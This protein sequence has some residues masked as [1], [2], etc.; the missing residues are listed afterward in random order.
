MSNEMMPLQQFNR[1]KECNKINLI[2]CPS[3]QILT[4]EN[5][6]LLNSNLRK[7]CS[8]PLKQCHKAFIN[9]I[10]YGNTPYEMV[11]KTKCCDCGMIL[12][13]PHLSPRHPYSFMFCK[14][15]VVYYLENPTSVSCKHCCGSTSSIKSSKDISIISKI[16]SFLTNT[17]KTLKTI[18]SLKTIKILSSE[19]GNGF[20]SGSSTQDSES[21]ENWKSDIEYNIGSLNI[22]PMIS[23]KFDGIDGKMIICDWNVSVKYIWNGMLYEHFIGNCNIPDQTIPVEYVLDGN[24]EQHYF[25][26]A[27]AHTLINNPYYERLVNVFKDVHL[28][29]VV[30]ID[31]WFEILCCNEHL[32]ITGLIYIDTLIKQMKPHRIIEAY[33]DNPQNHDSMNFQ[34]DIKIASTIEN[35]Y[36]PTVSSPFKVFSKPLPLPYYKIGTIVLPKNQIVSMLNYHEIMY[37]G[38]ETFSYVRMRGDKVNPADLAK[39]NSVLYSDINVPTTLSTSRL[40]SGWLEKRSQKTYEAMWNQHR[41]IKSHL[42]KIYGTGC[43]IT[44]FYAHG[45]PNRDPPNRDHHPV[46]QYGLNNGY[47]LTK[48]QT[49]KHQTSVL[50]CMADL[51]FFTSPS[52]L[53]VFIRNICKA[54]TLNAT[55]VMTFMNDKSDCTYFDEKGNIQ[56]SVRTGNNGFNDSNQINVYIHPRRRYYNEN[57]INLYELMSK[58]NQYNITCKMCLPFPEYARKNLI[59]KGITPC[60]AN[61]PITKRYSVLVLRRH[62]IDPVDSIQFNTTVVNPLL[63]SACVDLSYL[64]PCD[65]MQWCASCKAI[66]EFN[67]NR[68]CLRYTKDVSVLCQKRRENHNDVK[69]FASEHLYNQ[70]KVSLTR[71]SRWIGVDITSEFTIIKENRLHLLTSYNDDTDDDVYYYDDDYG[72]YW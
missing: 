37:H 38:N 41:A 25:I 7:K 66:Y 65:V 8:I 49:F 36:A 54:T 53:D 48:D 21:P 16:S 39:W 72:P 46:Y 3:C 43:A 5:R 17:D 24:N 71:L 12:L 61:H 10:D 58:F 23:L 42:F 63:Y 69:R 14:R 27:T 20:D 13:T 31:K 60:V 11:T 35:I 56:F 4:Y 47:D 57:A 44:E 50:F 40:S 67:I 28:K 68:K 32:P 64:D 59:S 1:C 22:S 33:L 19:G 62:A 55:I 18:K 45:H 26:E 2:A 6:N 51:H 9:E 52:Y 30:T 34:Y 15:C 70:T 29:P